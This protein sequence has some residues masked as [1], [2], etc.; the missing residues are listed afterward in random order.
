MNLCYIC[1]WTKNGG[2]PQKGF[3][4]NS[5]RKE[6]SQVRISLVSIFSNS[7]YS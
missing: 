6:D 4:G 3:F 7:D 1:D 5:P 2:V